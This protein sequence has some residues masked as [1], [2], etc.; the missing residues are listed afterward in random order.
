[1]SDVRVREATIQDAATIAV[2]NLRLAWET[3]QLRLD[4]TKVERGVRGLFELPARGTYYVAEIGGRVVACLLITHEWSDWRDGD[5]WWIQSVYVHEDARRQGV[6]KTMYTHVRDAAVA[7]EVVALRLY[8]EKHNER[9]QQ[10]YAGLG[11]TLTDY[12]MMHESL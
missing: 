8:V 10:A 3:E 6:F 2:F 5:M 4:P 12:R 9:A 1:M 7:A 11:M